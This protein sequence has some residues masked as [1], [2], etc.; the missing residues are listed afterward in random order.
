MYLRV[1]VT[2]INKF[3]NNLKFTVMGR[4]SK[5]R[6]RNRAKNRGAGTL[7]KCTPITL[8]F[9][10]RDG[11]VGLFKDKK[12]LKFRVYKAHIYA[13]DMSMLKPGQK[14]SVT[15]EYIVP[16]AN[17]RLVVANPVPQQ[18]PDSSE[19]YLWEGE[20]NVVATN[21]D[22][23]RMGLPIG[24]QYHHITYKEYPRVGDFVAG[25]RMG[26]YRHIMGVVK[27]VDKPTGLCVVGDDYAPIEEIGYRILN[28]DFLKQ[29]KFA[30]A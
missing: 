9:L 21:H 4:R 10:K 23:A 7:V 2:I 12:G 19:S 22:S 6:K 17:K 14:V 25:M 5:N 20:P 27:E 15:E 24:T 18:Q 26:K 3:T 16:V 30:N 11:D 13:S 28:P 8:K 1:A 29:Y